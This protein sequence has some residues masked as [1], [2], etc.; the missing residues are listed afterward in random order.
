MAKCNTVQVDLFHGE[1]YLRIEAPNKEH[2]VAILDDWQK[3]SL[4][5]K[6]LR[7]IK[8]PPKRRR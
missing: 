3:L 5:K 2:M 7:G 4:A 6:L 1:T 8:L